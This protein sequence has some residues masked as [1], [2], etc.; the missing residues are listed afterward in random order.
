MLFR[1][2][3]GGLPRC[4]GLGFTEERL[5]HA[6][7]GAAGLFV[8]VVEAGLPVPD[9]PTDP[10]GFGRFTESFV[11]VCSRGVIGRGE[12]AELTDVY[13]PAEVLR[14]IAGGLDGGEKRPRG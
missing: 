6:G 3:L 10:C 11:V 13:W 9:S 5:A 8:P 12:T 2:S 14:P 7:L 1:C 4:A